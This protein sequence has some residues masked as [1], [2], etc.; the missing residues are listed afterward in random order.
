MTRREVV[1]LLGC[2]PRPKT[3]IKIC[4]GSIAAVELMHEGEA[5]EVGGLIVY[6]RFDA[7]G[8]VISQMITG[9][10][11]SASWPIRICRW[12]NLYVE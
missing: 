10:P 3:E 5:W 8:R 1:D 6:V 12:M 4:G 11:Y 7:S 9:F 2:E